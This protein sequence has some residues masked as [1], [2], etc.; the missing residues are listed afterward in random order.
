MAVL[1]SVVAIGDVLRLDP[2]VVPT[3]DVSLVL[4]DP[5]DAAVVE[6]NEIVD[7]GGS[8]DDVD[9]DEDVDAESLLQDDSR[10]D[11]VSVDPVLPIDMVLPIC[12]PIAFIGLAS[13]G[14]LY[15]RGGGGAGGQTD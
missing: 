9:N 10:L 6:P 11:S 15:G 2:R 3:E 12:I 4:F 14:H 1:R 7:D 8:Q 5:V 13:A